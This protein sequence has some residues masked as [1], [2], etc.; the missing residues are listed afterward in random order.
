MRS[1]GHDEGMLRA[2]RDKGVKQET[3]FRDYAP[4][5]F[6]VRLDVLTATHDD[7]RDRYGSKPQG[8]LTHE[9]CALIFA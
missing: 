5:R 2:G 7:S 6:R 9:R 3:R 1:D 8:P 4:T